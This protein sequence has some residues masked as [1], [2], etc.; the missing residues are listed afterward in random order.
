MTS[1]VHAQ[2]PPGFTLANFGD[3][4]WHIY[5]DDPFL[6]FQQRVKDGS[7]K[8]SHQSWVARAGI[9]HVEDVHSAGHVQFEMK[10]LPSF[11]GVLRR[12]TYQFGGVPLTA[13]DEEALRV[14]YR[15]ACNLPARVR[16]QS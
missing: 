5:I 4:R 14:A 13:E 16:S 11:E 1:P 10:D 9:L 8:E 2:R 15:K 6:R 7:V 12:V 3:C